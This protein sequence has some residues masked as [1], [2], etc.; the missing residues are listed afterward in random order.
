MLNHLL[1][2]KWQHSDPRK[3]Q[4]ALESGNLPPEVLAT[5]A[6]E[7]SDQDVRCSAILR[8]DDPDLL[9]G[10]L[11]ED[12]VDQVRETVLRRQSELLSRPLE[13]PPSLDKRLAIIEKFESRDLCERLARNAVAAE[14]RTAALEQV[15]DTPLLCA[16]AVDDPVASV[17]QKALE[18]INE[19]E[20]WEIVSRNARKKDKTISRAARQRL[21]SFHKAISDQ[22]ATERLCREIDNLQAA[23]SR[24]SDSKV[25]FHRLCKQWQEITSPIPAQLS[26]RFDQARRLFATRIE[27]FDAQIDTRRA[28]CD[29]L[30]ALLDRIQRA[31]KDNP[32]FSDELASHMKALDERWQA[33]DPHL[34]SDT[35]VTQRFSDL[36]Q[37]LRLASERL[38]R[39][40]RR[41]IRLRELI[42]S[43]DALMQ[44]PDKLN[45]NQ[46]K[47]LQ[48]RWSK[49]DKPESRPLAKSLQNEFE[50][51]LRRSRQHLKQEIKRHTQAL[52]EAEQLLPELQEALNHGALERALS[53]RDRINH[54]LKL[55]NS[56]E[57]KRQDTLQKQL[58][59]QRVKIDELKQWR[60]WGSGNAREHL[61]TEIEALIGSTLSEDEIAARVRS[62]RK[63]W[64]SIDH[65]EG[66]ADEA[67][68][69][70]FD[71]AC[72]SAY[73]P[74]QQQRKQQKERLK[75]HLAQ[76]RK[77]ITELRDFESN[78]DWDKVDWREA[79][80]HIHKARER[81]RRIGSIP[82]KT[83]KSLEKDY[84]DV[85]DLLESRL[86]PERIRELKRRRALIA[87]V[88]EL[89]RASDLRSA[90]R[91][92]KAAQDQWKP[93]VPLPRKEEQALWQHFRS[94]CDAVFDQH[95]KQRIS[96][97]AEREANLE[98]RQAICAELESLLDQPQKPFREIHKQFAATSD[99]WRQF[100]NIPRKQER[101][102]DARYEGIKQRLAERQRQEAKTAAETRLLSIREYSLICARLE[103]EVLD[104][105]MDE[106][107][108][109]ALLSECSH[110]R[111]ALPEFAAQDAKP[112]QARYELASRALQ[113]DSAAQA[114]LCAG[115][116]KNLQ[117]RLQLCL[118]LEV[119]TGMDSPAEYAD[120]R[121]KY[122]VS[123]LSDAMQHKHI[124]EESE[125]DRL[126]ALGIAWLQAGPVNQQERV[127][128]TERFER[129]FSA[130]K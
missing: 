44:D 92:V 45:E 59:Q 27:E 79:E 42:S 17:R 77:L 30:D 51:S 124:D 50:D 90:S 112:L 81:W 71:Q 123:L 58:S 14:I 130:G 118:Q 9:A 113:G 85:F 127:K 103:Q 97:D 13:L 75:Q 74:Y 96:A 80:Q 93:T 55:A 24:V 16:V 101:A 72:T 2:P 129:A 111:Q 65:A 66:P 10:L 33:T 6:R 86:A 98:R 52:E 28:V 34:N 91:G 54:R 43:A 89:S 67:L 35:A 64:Q 32:D 76:K 82:R 41:M 5:V 38:D 39:D 116:A 126:T 83:G 87:R 1:K 11:Q 19:P 36:K 114:S 117:Q 49:L 46:I 104:Q 94:A 63:A 121:M 84:R 40:R 128:L 102:I 20:G 115:L 60:H 4:A 25:V 47:Q 69:Q 12:L 106:A 99:E 122:Q 73:E 37:Q 120:E 8:V 48:L 53:L 70:R 23:G 29:E 21:N 88:E 100:R 105:T 31:N 22:K 78:T 56:I 18:Q 7:D 57:K 108:R 61:I 62:A 3:R 125:E 68:W 15:T 109:Q 107:A 95:R 110:N 119:A 26:E